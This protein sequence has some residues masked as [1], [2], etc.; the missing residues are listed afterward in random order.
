[1][2]SE[3]QATQA[4][5]PCE[6]I[7]CCAHSVI[8]HPAQPAADRRRQKT[9]KHFSRLDSEN[10]NGKNALF[11]ID[12]SWLVTSIGFDSSK[13]NPMLRNACSALAEAR[14]IVLN[15]LRVSNAESSGEHGRFSTSG[16]IPALAQ[17]T[18]LECVGKI[19]VGEIRNPDRK[20]LQKSNNASR[21]GT[22][23]L[24]AEIHRVRSSKADTTV[25]IL[26]LEERNIV[27][28]VEDLQDSDRNPSKV[29]RKREARLPLATK[30]AS[31]RASNRVVRR[32]REAAGRS[33]NGSLNSVRLRI[34]ATPMDAE[35]RASRRLYGVLLGSWDSAGSLLFILRRNQQHA[36]EAIRIQLVDRLRGEHGGQSRTH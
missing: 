9:S 18:H 6:S 32:L 16:I 27:L 33:R 12:K 35:I 34:M 14:S 20:K 11:R 36:R 3:P 17:Q 8:Q 25:H 31:S 22:E 24:G 28:N 7:F 19:D 2:E 15:L 23:V 10:T 5:T 30:G 4:S 29:I 13:E 26:L 21:Q 1:M